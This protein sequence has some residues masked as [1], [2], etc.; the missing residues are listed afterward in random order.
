MS[1]LVLVFAA[2]LTTA[3]S[4]TAPYGAANP[5]SGLPP[6]LPSVRCFFQNGVTNL[7]QSYWG[8]SVT[9]DN[10]HL[11][12][13]AETTYAQYG[14]NA[15]I[16]DGPVVHIGTPCRLTSVTYLSGP[17]P[18][19]DPYQLHFVCAGI[20]T[21][22]HQGD[23]NATKPATAGG[24]CATGDSDYTCAGNASGCTNMYDVGLYCVS[25]DCGY[26]QLYC[27]IGP[28][29]YNVASPSPESIVTFNCTQGA[30]ALAVGDYGVMMGTNC[31]NGSVP[32]ANGVGA[33]DGVGGTNCLTGEG[34]GGP[35]GYGGKGLTYQSATQIYAWKYFTFSANTA[36]PQGGHCLI[37][38][39]K[40]DNTIGVPASLTSY[41]PGGCSLVHS[42][43]VLSPTGQ[44]PHA[45]GFTWWSNQ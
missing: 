25:T 33:T 44:A 15:M 30:V 21:T 6:T 36:A 29:P 27:N 11:A 35:F 42:A 28:V 10:T 41:D 34:E 20:G 32:A 38:D 45:L 3:V 13:S 9:H 23:T 31:D 2:L 39:P 16:F 22:N 24:N 5:A 26:G 17:T 18:N 8:N 19:T 4:Q 43:V 40:H 1:K 7:A 12:Q 37:F 14:N